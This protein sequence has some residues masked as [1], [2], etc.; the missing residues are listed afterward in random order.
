MDTAT[1]DRVCAK[2]GLVSA[3]PHCG[4]KAANWVA[5]GGLVH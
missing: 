3:L 1:I 2:R 5:D 4:L